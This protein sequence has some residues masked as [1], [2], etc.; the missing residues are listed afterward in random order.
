MRDSGGINLPRAAASSDTPGVREE[1]SSEVR[2]ALL[3][4]STGGTPERKRAARKGETHFL[5]TVG[6]RQEK[7]CRSP[8]QQRQP[9]E[10]IPSIPLLRGLREQ[11]DILSWLNSLPSTHPCVSHGP[12]AKGDIQSPGTAPPECNPLVHNR[13]S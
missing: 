5:N 7:V 3:F 6:R 9:W 10:N 13:I 12:W 2:G 1:S 8:E 4:S 11:L